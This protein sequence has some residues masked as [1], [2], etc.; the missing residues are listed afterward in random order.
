MPN[1]LLESASDHL[2][3]F[4]VVVRLLFGIVVA[5]ANLRGLWICVL[6]QY[7]VGLKVLEGPPKHTCARGFTGW[8]NS[9][10]RSIVR[11]LG[12]LYR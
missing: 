6:R 12:Q 4:P 5:S 1:I 2:T 10:A 9:L 8:R 11:N 7:F 3:I